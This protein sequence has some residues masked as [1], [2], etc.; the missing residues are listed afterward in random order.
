[1]KLD[2]E[3]GATSI[4]EKTKLLADDPFAFMANDDIC[5]TEY[6]PENLTKWQAL[7]QFDGSIFA[8]RALW[9][10]ILL[11]IL[12]AVGVA[13]AVAYT[14]KPDAS[15]ISSD[16]LT[17]VVKVM[18]VS[19]AFLLGMFMSACLS[20]WW[21]TVK[22]IESLFGSI[23]KL[24][25]T[26]IN[27][28]L[29]EEFCINLGRGCVLSVLMMETEMTVGK[30]HGSQ[31]ENWRNRFDDLA[32]SGQIN[33]EERKI[34]ES[35]APMERSFFSWSLVSNELCEIRD[36]LQ[37][38]GV[39]DTVAYDRLCE[40]VGVGT[41]SVSALKTIMT[42]QIPFVYVH[43]LAFM[44][45]AVNLLN[46]VGAGLQ[47]GVAYANLGRVDYGAVGNSLVF[48]I[49]QSFIYQ[50]FLSIG[51]AL[52]F[53]VSASAYKIPLS[54]MTGTLE[55]QL[56][57]MTRLSFDQPKSAVGSKTS[58]PAPTTRKVT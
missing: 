13:G 21:D 29:P 34:L 5:V 11:Q 58:S 47:I 14:T 10:V 42:F 57:T 40:L 52:S 45:H 53:P 37:T 18:T 16:S 30:M 28:Q 22:S 1:M 48:L 25:M 35:V 17:S 27:L 36:K 49:L 41:S 33:Q 24:V 44:V 7:V 26:A 46:A 4:T 39:P 23:K 6:D 38:G 19:I 8:Q 31:E 32:K 43:M 15:H 51:A 56:R 55:R 54:R 2:L 12:T 50:A 9:V 3:K 20:R